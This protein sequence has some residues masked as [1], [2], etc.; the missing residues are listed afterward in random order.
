MFDAFLDGSAFNG[1]VSVGDVK[2]QQGLIGVECK[3]A[4]HRLVTDF[5]TVFPTGG[6]LARFTL[7]VDPVVEGGCDGFRDEPTQDVAKCKWGDAC[8]GFCKWNDA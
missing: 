7:G 4:Q 3:R 5:A 1:V 2:R 8:V 6:V